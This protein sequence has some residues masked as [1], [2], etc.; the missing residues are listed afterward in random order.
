MGTSSLSYV[1]ELQSNF[2]RERE[3]ERFSNIFTCNLHFYK[4]QI[5]WVCEECWSLWGSCKDIFGINKHDLY[6]SQTP[7]NITQEKHYP[8]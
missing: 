2:E 6:K 3:R 8:L 1:L 4:K 7:S 5:V